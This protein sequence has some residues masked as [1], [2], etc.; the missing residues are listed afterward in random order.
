MELAGRPSGLVRLLFSSL[1][2]A[3]SVLSQDLR[4]WKENCLLQTASDLHTHIV[5][6]HLPP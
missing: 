5:V 1:S 3:A 4:W 6:N 2:L